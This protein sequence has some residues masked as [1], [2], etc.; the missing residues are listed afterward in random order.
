MRMFQEIMEG[1]KPGLIEASFIS[2]SGKKIP[3][4]GMVNTHFHGG[5]P[6]YTRAIYRVVE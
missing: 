6:Q 2:K 3:I 5:K 4:Q 1:K